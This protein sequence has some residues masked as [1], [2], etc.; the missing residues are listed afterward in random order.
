MHLHPHTFDRDGTYLRLLD[1]KEQDVFAAYLNKLSA[2]VADMG[3]V[4][5]Y[6]EAWAATHGNWMADN[7]KRAENWQEKSGSKD[8]VA[9]LMFVR[10][11][12]TCESHHEVMSTFWRLLEESRLAEAREFAPEID[13]LLDISELNL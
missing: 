13:K 11:L 7:L 4:R 10:N 5:K 12:F 8:G 2:P 9:G 1:K 6:F 3:L